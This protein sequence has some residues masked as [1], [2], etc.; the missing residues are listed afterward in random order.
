MVD[1]G[2]DSLFLLQPSQIVDQFSLYDLSLDVSTKK[3]AAGI[4]K[5]YTLLKLDIYTPFQKLKLWQIRLQLLIFNDQQN[6]AKREAIRLNNALY[7]AESDHANTSIYPLPKL[8]EIVPVSLLL[9][10]NRLKNLPGLSTV[11]ALHTL[12]YQLR[13]KPYDFDKKKIYLQVIA[14]SIFVNLILIRSDVTALNLLKSLYKQSDGVYKSN[15]SM[16]IVLLE[17]KLTKLVNPI[18][19]DE[20]TKSSLNI[21]LK[22]SID[23]SEVP[24]FIDPQDVDRILVELASL[25]L[26]S[27]QYDFD[28]VEGEFNSTRKSI[29]VGGSVETDDIVEQILTESNKNWGDHLHNVFQKVPRVNL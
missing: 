13:L 25:Y 28:I 3:F 6:L 7:A 24:S 27:I 22:R 16:L 20:F 17:Y 4:H 2:Q 18:D 8:S 10:L 19:L 14:L 23:V 1:L 15:V 9:L 26:V 11:N 21:V 5:T 12:T 29:D